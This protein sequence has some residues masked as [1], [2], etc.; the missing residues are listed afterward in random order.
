MGF[1]PI[2]CDGIWPFDESIY[3]F[4]KFYAIFSCFCFLFFAAQQG[5][6]RIIK[7]R[8][9]FVLTIICILVAR[10][11][12]ILYISILYFVFVIFLFFVFCC[13]EILLTHFF[14]FLLQLNMHDNQ[15]EKKK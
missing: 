13:A 8:D 7:E 4:V 5:N 15:N 9:A 10:N 11:N 1:F 2:F 6:C 3:F 12:V 14:F